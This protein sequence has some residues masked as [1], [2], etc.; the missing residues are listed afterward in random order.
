MKLRKSGMSMIGC[1]CAAGAWVL[2]SA[3]ARAQEGG[4]PP[5][6]VVVDAARLENVVQQRE[7]TGE[8][9]ALRRS[10][11]ASEEVGL[12][13]ALLVDEGD[14]VQAG[15]V[16]ATLESTLAKHGLKRAA[17]VVASKAGVVGERRAEVERARRE[18]ARLEE[19]ATRSGVT[20][21]ERDERRTS[22]TGWEG[23]LA[24]AEGE[25]AEA[26]AELARAE[27]SFARRTI[28]APFAGRIVRKRTEVGQWLKAGD[29]VAEV[30]AM[31]VLE[32]RLNVPESLID[33]I[34]AG[35][36]SGGGG[37]SGTG[38]VRVR[39]AALGEEREAEIGEII[40]DADAL[41][42]LFP[43]RLKLANADE[44]LKPGMSV[45]GLV[46]TGRTAPTL[47]VSKD[48]VLRDDAGEF[49]YFDAGGAAQVARV[50]TLYA[51]GGGRVAVRAETLREGAGVVTRGNE[52][53]YPG[54]RLMVGAGAT[55][56][57]TDGAATDPKV[58]RSSGNPDAD[59]GKKEPR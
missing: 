48:A 26:E 3:G 33:L 15:Q 30:V 6:P 50:R 57:G 12:V 23:R 4:P 9:R 11:M 51:S 24:Q 1:V 47:T 44:R 13:S 56:A 34:R 45:T 41:S 2:G 40:P 32:A 36:G 53:L 35:G 29:P 37:A 19:A 39:V 59:G 58:K 18:L 8:I 55:G 17:A 38:R 14:A 7:V 31:D 21:M 52:R 46:P 43:V 20:E 49:V 28:R 16:I 25:R 22:V 42:R 10:V 27:E 5:M 54:A